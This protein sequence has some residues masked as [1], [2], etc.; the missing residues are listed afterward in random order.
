MGVFEVAMFIML[1]LL[2]KFAR[3]RKKERAVT[4]KTENRRRQEENCQHPWKHSV[5]L[6]NPWYLTV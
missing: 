5:I 1:R 4:L 6:G 3:E 2:E